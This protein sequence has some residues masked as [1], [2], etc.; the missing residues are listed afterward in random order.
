MSHLTEEIWAHQD[1]QTQKTDP[2]A[3]SEKL[4]IYKTITLAS[5]ETILNNSL[6]LDF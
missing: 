1:A 5:E 4:I 6:I 3:H 2:V